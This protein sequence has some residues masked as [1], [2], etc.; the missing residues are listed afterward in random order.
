MTVRDS[1]IELLTDWEAPDS[2]QDALRHAVLAFLNARD[3]RMPT[4]LRR[5]ACHRLGSGRLRLRR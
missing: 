3:R 4:Q 5:R 2:A 1:A